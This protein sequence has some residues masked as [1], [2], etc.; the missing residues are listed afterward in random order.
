L[1][2]GWDQFK[3]NALHVCSHYFSLSGSEKIV[4]VGLR[5]I[6]L[7]ALEAPL[8][9]AE[10]FAVYPE[11]PSSY[12]MDVRAYQVQLLFGD[13]SKGSSVLGRL[14]MQLQQHCP[15][16]CVPDNNPPCHVEIV[17]L[18]DPQE[19]TSRSVWLAVAHVLADAATVYTV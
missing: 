6:N 3:K 13:E 11:I 1:Y 12:P 5:T 17:G 16:E 9:I 7:I 4:R 19:P 8:K 14:N 2:A 18:P 10:N 15:A